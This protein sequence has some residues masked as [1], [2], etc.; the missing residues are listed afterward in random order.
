VKPGELLFYPK[1]WRHRTVNLN[2]PT[3]ALTGTIAD[4]NNHQSLGKE[5][6]A[7]CVWNKHKF[8]FSAPLCDALDECFE[9]WRLKFGGRQFRPWRDMA[10]PE[11]IKNKKPP[12]ENN[13]NTQRINE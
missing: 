7:E 6:S 5:L 2:T 10:S 11:T 8:G 12:T 1:L 9:D 4:Q 13:Y 3:M